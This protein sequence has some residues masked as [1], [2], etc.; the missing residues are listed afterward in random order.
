MN[1][2]PKMNRVGSDFL[3]QYLTAC[4][5]ENIE[6]YLKPDESCFDNPFDYPNMEE[7]VD[8]FMSYI[9]SHE[10][11]GYKVGIVMD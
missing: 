5:I 10:K 3:S 2:I 9:I 8:I 1:V 6:A 11:V 4:G 7:A